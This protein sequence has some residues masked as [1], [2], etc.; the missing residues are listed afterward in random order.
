MH[1]LCAARIVRTVTRIPMQRRN[2]GRS[3]ASLPAALAVA[4]FVVAAGVACGGTTPGSGTTPTD[5]ALDWAVN[6]AHAGLLTTVDRGFDRSRGVALRLRTPPSSSD[7]VR[8]LL[9]GRTDFAVL[10]IHDLAIARSRGRDLVAVMSIVGRPLAAVIGAPDIARPR[11][12][13]GRSVAVTGTPSDRAVVRA[14]VE[15]DGGDPGRVSLRPSGWAATAALIGGR[16]DGAVGFAN[17]EGVSLAARGR[18]HRVFKLADSKAPP[19][20]ELVLVTTRRRLAGNPGLVG[21]VVAAIAEG[22]RTAV[23]QPG[24]TRKLLATK[25]PGADRDLLARR[26]GAALGLMLPPNGKAGSL[27]RRTMERWASWEA[28]S[29]IVPS[30]PDLDRLMTTRFSGG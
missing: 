23:S 30:P 14:V 12:L 18:G 27:D 28:S 3:G 11:D 4:V 22:T 13:E 16:T 9:S 8:L 5:V 20:P 1:V 15:S 17:E 24:S 10:D 7:G 21:A 25:L 29:G 2:G 19:Y 6:P 26:T